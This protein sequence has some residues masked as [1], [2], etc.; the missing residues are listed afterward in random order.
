MGGSYNLSNFQNRNSEHPTRRKLTPV[1]GQENVYDVSREEGT[2]SNEGTPWNADT[3]NKF[4][5]KIGDMFPVKIENG[6]TGGTNKTSAVNNLMTT[7]TFTPNLYSSA[8]QT[9]PLNYSNAGDKYGVY[10]KLGRFVYVNI[11]IHNCKVSESDPDG[12]LVIGTLPFANDVGNFT[13]LTVGEFA[14]YSPDF[15]RDRSVSCSIMNG[16]QMI[17]I[18]KGDGGTQVSVNEVTNHACDAIISGV[19]ITNA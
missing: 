3:M 18:L 8:N 12:Y 5:K 9:R 2:V 13:T 6:G 1:A 19:Y 17:R 16:G 7:G 14:L 4:D 11:R 15:E 10:Y